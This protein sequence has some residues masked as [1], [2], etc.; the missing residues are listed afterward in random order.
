MDR[1][2]THE[3]RPLPSF[4]NLGGLGHEGESELRRPP[5]AGSLLRLL[6]FMLATI[7]FWKM[8]VQSPGAG[9]R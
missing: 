5:R 9:I 7:I 3:S 8:K 2:C 4:S 1:H 6:T